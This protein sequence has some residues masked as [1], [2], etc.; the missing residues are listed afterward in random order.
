MLPAAI[1][2]EEAR[3]CVALRCEAWSGFGMEDER[4]VAARLIRA[5]AITS[6]LVGCMPCFCAC[7]R[8]IAGWMLAV[9]AMEAHEQ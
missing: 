4:V 9:Q 7:F 1:S 3:R 5:R 8:A 2:E 6:P